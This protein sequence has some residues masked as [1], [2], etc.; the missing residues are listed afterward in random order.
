MT[1]LTV[2]SL[3]TA[4]LLAAPVWAQE[5][6][7]DADKPDAPKQIQPVPTIDKQPAKKEKAEEK[8]GLTVGD[9]A[10]E[11]KV[12]AFVKGNP[13]KSFESG[14]VYVVEFW[15]TWCGPCVAAFPHLSE[16]QAKYK[17]KVTFIGTNIWERPYNADTL[18]KVKDFVE[19]QG[20]KMAYTVAFDGKAA[21]MDS[22]YMKAAGR[23]GIPCAFIV[24]QEGKIA[25]IGHPMSMDDVLAQVVE[26]KYDIDAAQK[27]AKAAAESEGKLKDINSRIMKAARADKWDEVVTGIDELIKADPEHKSMYLTR[28]YG[29]LLTKK[30]D[31]A[32]AYGMK[33]VL[34]AEKG[35]GDESQA[36]NEIAWGIV[37]PEGDVPKK[38]RNLDFAMA[39]ALK[40][41]EVA[42]GENAAILDTVA[43]VYWDKGDRAKAIEFQEKAVKA[44]DKDGTAENMK[45]EIK[46]TLENYKKENAKSGA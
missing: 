41:N 35:I 43:R 36:L 3:L 23:N 13:V 31:Y 15:A 24:N 8:K 42:K 14:K 44:A 7:P 11:L 28:K 16:N 19:E 30:Q 45:D 25:W 33:D 26:G 37:N 1:K 29:I 12:E 46:A 38:D 17:D 39:F 40:A 34:L 21:A 32:A 27:K 20:D 5:S 4:A 2:A 10:P 9:K 6:K 18:Q 22:A